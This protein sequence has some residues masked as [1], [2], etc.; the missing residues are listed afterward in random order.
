MHLYM[1]IAVLSI[2]QLLQSV[3][4]LLLIAIII[5][6]TY[7]QILLRTHFVLWGRINRWYKEPCF[8][9]QRL[10]GNGPLFSFLHV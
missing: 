9:P 7:F 4:L 6:L 5:I 10:P 1:L 8:D 2:E 3:L